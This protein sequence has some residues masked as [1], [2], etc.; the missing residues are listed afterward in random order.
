MRTPPLAAARV[1]PA[2]SSLARGVSATWWYT[3]SSVLFLEGTVVF[4]WIAALAGLDAEPSTIAVTAI[5][6][7]LWWVSTVPLLLSYRHRTE[8]GHPVASRPLLLCLLLAAAFGALAGILAGNLLIALTPLVVSGALLNWA[9]GIRLRLVL[10]VTV[11]LAVLFVWEM[12]VLLVEGPQPFFWMIG[13][14]SAGLPGSVVTL[15]WWWDVIVALDEARAAE[16]RL[17]ATQERL[18]VATDV[19]DLQGHHLQVI[20]LQLELAERLMPRDEEAAMEQ[21]RAARASVDEARQGTRDLARGIR[22]IPLVDELSNAIDLLCA[23][24]IAAEAQIAADANSAPADVLGPIIRET[25]TNILRHGAGEQASLRLVRD[26][27]EWMYEAVNDAVAAEPSTDGAGI[28]GIRRRVA[29]VQGTVETSS[30]QD[31]FTLTVRV[32]A[33]PIG[34]AA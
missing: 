27:A 30:T 20:A 23:A 16:A 11:L 34:T 15:L 12:R 28:E 14:Y 6:G 10:V 25:T 24:G 7:L 33:V 21:L 2:P 4:I 13:V 5:G 8:S 19:H 9:P 18:R 29:E 22:S 31:V 1:S 26:G 3:A 32:P 17:A